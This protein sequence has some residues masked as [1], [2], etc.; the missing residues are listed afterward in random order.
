[1][2]KKDHIPIS[3]VLIPKTIGKRQAISLQGLLT[4]NN[5]YVVFS[6]ISMLC[7]LLFTCYSHRPLLWP[8]T[9]EGQ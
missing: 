5:L 3:L 4:V 8:S 1:M 7:V 2:R 6:F 9:L